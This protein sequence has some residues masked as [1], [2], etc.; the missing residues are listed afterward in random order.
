[1]RTI[2]EFRELMIAVLHESLHRPAFY[3]C[4][5]RTADSFYS[6]IISQLCWID[7]REA[8][9]RHL[10]VH[11]GMLGGPMGVYG[12]FFDQHLSIPDRFSNE[13]A[14]TYAQAA[15]RLGYFSPERVLAEKEFDKLKLALGRNFMKIDHVMSEIVLQFGKPSLDVL[16]GQTT[17]HC[18]GSCDRNASWI[19]F[20]YSRC[21]PPIDSRTFDWFDEP[22]LRDIRKMNNKMKLLPFGAWCRDRTCSSGG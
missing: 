19:Y 4:V 15:Y 18:Y 11:D 5:G 22:K 14:S 1:M 9:F 13:I 12:Q 21:F 2:E 16:G 3:C 10:T 17:V 7:E 6:Q 8:E 20:D